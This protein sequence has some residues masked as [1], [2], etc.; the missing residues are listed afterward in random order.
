MSRRKLP[1]VGGYFTE[2]RTEVHDTHPQFARSDIFCVR[3]T[4]ARQI[5]ADERLGV[6][7]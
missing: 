7:Q 6:N 5:E 3:I 2:T 1:L 4:K